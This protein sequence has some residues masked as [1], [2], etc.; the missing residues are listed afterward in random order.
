MARLA[1]VE[2]VSPLEEADFVW[3]SEQEIRT[4]QQDARAE[5]HTGAQWNE[6]RL[7]MTPAGQVWILTSA[8][9]LHQRLCV[10]A[11]AGASGQLR[12]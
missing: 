9:E 4:L 3:P 7:V 5:D 8:G 1:V 2:R 11:H 12:H 10:I 6:E